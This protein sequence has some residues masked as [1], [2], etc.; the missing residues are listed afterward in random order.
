MEDGVR[1]TG[2]RREVEEEEEHANRCVE[3]P[4]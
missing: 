4:R 2:T 3:P 1:V